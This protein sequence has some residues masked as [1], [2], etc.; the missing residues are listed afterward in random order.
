MN[1]I[2]KIPTS[3]RW[4]FSASILMLLSANFVNAGNMLYNLVFSRWMGPTLF[5]DL[6]FLLTLKLTIL[7]VFNALQFLVTE[8]VADESQAKRETIIQY[9]RHLSA[10]SSL[11]LLVSIP[12]IIG[13]AIY[14]DWSDKLGLSSELSLLIFFLAIPLYLPLAL[15]RGVAQG[16]L[17]IRRIIL[18]ANVEMLVRFLGGAILWWAGFGISSV[19]FAFVL[20]LFLAWFF[21]KPDWPRKTTPVASSKEALPIKNALPW[22]AIQIAVVLSLDGDVFVAKLFLDSHSAGLVAALSLVQ[23]IIFFASFS[24][25]T[26]LLPQVI[27]DINNGGNGFRRAAPIFGLVL[28]TAVPVLILIFFFPKISVSVLFGNAFME[29]APLLFLAGVNSTII[30]LNYFIVILMMAYKRK[31]FA[32]AFLLLSVFQLVYLHRVIVFG[33]GDLHSIVYQKFAFQLFAFTALVFLAL[34]LKPWNLLINSS[35]ET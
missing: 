5:S 31:N 7:S 8:K 3:F 17:D 23:R 27:Q 33:E 13:C 10:Y 19:I 30:T 28:I 25:A 29:I 2:A 18:S 20:S 1:V 6:A 35:Q 34:L 9:Y 22:A 15:V 21:A 24:L 11:V 14:F 32:F 26:I 12:F 16:R 4:I